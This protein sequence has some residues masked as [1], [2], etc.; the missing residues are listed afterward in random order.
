ME[1]Q[2][3]WLLEGDPA[4]RWQVMRDLLAAP[5]EDWQT[6]RARTSASG[7]GRQLLDQQD[8]DGT[9][10]GGIYSPKWVSTTYTLLNLID[11][12]VPPGCEAAARGAGIVID[13][14]LGAEYDNSFRE[15]LAALDRCIV[16][17]DLQIAAYF[18]LK[19]PRADA[20]VQNLLEEQMADGGWNCR[21]H[22]KPYPHH[23]SFHTTFNVL[24]G[25]R[26][27]VEANDD[28][29]LAEA[30]LAAEGRA[31]EL[32]LAHRFFRSD[33][34]GAVINDKFL[35]FSF[36][37]RWHYDVMRGLAYFARA[38]APCDERAQEAIEFL[39]TKRS[40]DGTWPVQNRYSGLVF[41]HMEPVGKKSRWNTLRALRILKW[42]EGRLG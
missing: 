16:G 28:H 21:R 27:W 36:P 34:T 35:L 12:G 11:I 17:M 10:G 20:I 1:T 23:S 25:L 2:I 8:P 29:P 7:W 3:D 41:F 22:R 13:R 18:G 32:M 4:I 26:E 38:G 30:V 37:H 24:E 14:Q 33:K 9:W 42:W 5:R 40:P 6:E 31:Q 39:I 19:G 15:R